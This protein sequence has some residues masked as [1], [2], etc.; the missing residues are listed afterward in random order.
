MKFERFRPTRLEFLEQLAVN[1]NRPWFQEN[2]RRYRRDLLEPSLAF[3]CA[4]QPRL[5]QIS[6][7]FAASDCGSGD[8]SCESTATRGSPGTG[9][10]TRRTSVLGHHNQTCKEMQR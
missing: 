10:R 9:S 2:K 5:K 7:Y 4:F 1:N 8:R 6:P 3:V